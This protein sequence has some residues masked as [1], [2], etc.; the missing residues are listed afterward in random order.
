MLFLFISV[1]GFSQSIAPYSQEF[2]KY[3]NE[4]NSG[5]HQLIT[6]DGH[7]LGGIPLPYE[8]YFDNMLQKDVQT[9]DPVYDLRTT[10]FLTPI[11]NQGSCG[12][13]WGRLNQNGKNLA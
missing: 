12:S 8:V 13:C 6:T 11:K 1:M 4:K 2:N 5:T 3:L 9:F 7:G 10:N